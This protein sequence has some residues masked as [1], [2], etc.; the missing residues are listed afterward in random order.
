MANRVA[1]ITRGADRKEA[2]T[3]ST[4]FLA[5]RRVHDDDAVARFDWT[6]R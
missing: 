5:K 1:A 4:A 2:I 6:R 3:A